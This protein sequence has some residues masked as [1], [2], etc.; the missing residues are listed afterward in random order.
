M[1]FPPGF[2][3][4][5]FRVLGERD[6]HYTTETAVGNRSPGGR[7]G[8]SRERRCG[9]PDFLQPRGRPLLLKGAPRGL[10]AAPPGIK[11]GLGRRERPQ[12]GKRSP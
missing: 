12:G 1:V 9:D 6:N 10:A 7:L 8:G 3:P 2:E 5:T 4:G 11:A